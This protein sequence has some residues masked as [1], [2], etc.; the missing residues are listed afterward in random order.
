[1]GKIGYKGAHGKHSTWE[2]QS[3]RQTRVHG[4]DRVQGSTCVRQGKREYIGK[5][6]HMENST[7]KYMGNF[8]GVYVRRSTC[9]STRAY[10]G[11]T[12]HGKKI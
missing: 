1:M 9:E 10:I 5:T 6:E 2:R 7:R 11:K 12:V 4:K 8:K 3:T